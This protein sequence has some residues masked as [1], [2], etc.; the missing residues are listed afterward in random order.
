MQLEDLRPRC[1]VRGV[2]PDG[3]V[4][5]VSVQW[6]GSEAVELTYKT[7]AGAVANELLY[8]HDETR[9]EVV[10][11]GRPWS[12]DGDGALFRLVSEA[13]RIRLAHLFDPLLA[14]HTSVVDPLP[15]QITGVYDAIDGEVANLG[16]SSACRRVARAVYLGSAPAAG[17]AQRGIEDRRIK[18]G[19]VLPGESPA[20]FGDALRRLAARATYLYQDGP[21]YWYDTRPT[22]TK[23]AEDRAEQLRR[24]SDRVAQAIGVRLRAA[25]HETGGFSRI[26]PAPRSGH[27]VPDERETRLVVLGID[28]PYRRDPGSAAETAAATILET[29]GTTPR[30]YRNTLVS[31]PGPD[32]ASGPG[33]GDSPPPG[34]G[35]DPRRARTARPVAPSGSTGGDAA[36]C[37]R[38]NRHGAAAGNVPVAADAGSGSARRSGHLGGGAADRAGRLGGSGSPPAQERR[39]AHRHLRRHE[40]P[41][42]ARPGAALARRPRVGPAARRGFRQLPLPAAPAGS[43]RAA[44]RSDGRRRPVDLGE[45]ELR[46][47]GQ[48]RR[49]H[50]AVSRTARR[51]RHSPS[52]M[53]MR[54]AYWSSRR[55]PDSNSTPNRPRPPCRQR[56]TPAGPTIPDRNPDRS[57][58]RRPTANRRASTG[59]FHSTQPAPD[60]TRAGSRTR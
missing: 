54:E 26:H 49:R 20:V 58:R 27:D 32:A 5:V 15:H 14:I 30:L 44:A 28:H 39:P 47:R 53:R 51:D 52:R 21:R 4:T 57:P 13:Q 24:D 12:F 45:R 1:A 37:R 10:A 29:R 18:L 34:L 41:D 33:R 55:S 23:L 11:Q 2:H 59:A 3:V 19:C 40:P 17:S 43:G 36:G 56:R 9:L 50:R 16:K 7:Q 42:G 48:L 60:E 8:R 31:G 25:L 46:L 6:F 38:R 35:V 22:V